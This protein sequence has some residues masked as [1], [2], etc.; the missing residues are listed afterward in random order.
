MGIQYQRGWASRVGLAGIMLLALNGCAGMSKA[1]NE[2]FQAVVAKNVSPGMSFVT[3]HLVKAGF[4]C[5]D[6]SSAPAISCTRSR[7]SILPFSCIHRVELMTDT[8]RETVVSVTPR[9]II[10]ASL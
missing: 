6:R 8:Y 4:S 1:D 7:D 9:P 10:C 2:R 5:D 3:K